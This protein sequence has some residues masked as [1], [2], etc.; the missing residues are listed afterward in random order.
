[1]TATGL[2]ANVPDSGMMVPNIVQLVNEGSEPFNMRYGPTQRLA[3]APGASLFVNE[4]VAW[5][6]LG[7]WW[8]DN[9]NPKTRERREEYGR[10]R[11]L[12]G[13]YEDETIWE[14]NRPRIVAYS[15]D[16]NRIT[17]VVDD[18]E[19]GEAQTPLG[20]EMSLEAQM[21]VMQDMVLRLQAQLD[22]RVQ[23]DANVGQ[24]SVPVD[25]TGI[26][27]VSSVAPGPRDMATIA[28]TQ[29]PVSPA[30]Y[31]TPPVEDEEGAP[32]RMPVHASVAFDPNEETAPED[33]PLIT[34]NGPARTGG[35]V[36]AGSS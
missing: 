23:D 24:P 10:L 25:V 16:G 33:A 5:H 26:Q 4:D 17:T 3:I 35:R 12:Y 9:S 31:I 18:P 30:P 19:G 2:T 34:P 20:R 7:R 22:G 8:T 11:T 15:P 28:G 13:A 1:M 14:K 27:S 29:V 36:S 21:G 6:F 32:A